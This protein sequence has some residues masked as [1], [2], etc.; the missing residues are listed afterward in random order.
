MFIDMQIAMSFHTQINA[1]M[2]CNLIEHVI[3]KAQAG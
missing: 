3:K 1:A 2:P